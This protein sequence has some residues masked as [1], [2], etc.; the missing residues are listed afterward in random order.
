MEDIN[1]QFQKS[2]IEFLRKAVDELKNQETISNDSLNVIFRRLH[3]I[4]GTAQTFDNVNTSELAHDL[5]NVLDLLRSADASQKE[6]LALLVEGFKFLILSLEYPDF[7]IPE[8]FLKKIRK[9]AT[10]RTPKL[11]SDIFLTLI[12]PEVFDQLTEYE[13]GKLHGITN[14]DVNI[15]GVDSVFK[16]ENVSEKL[17]Q[18]QKIL[19]KFGEIAF[20]LPSE[21]ELKENEIGFHIFIS[22]K[23]DVEVISE[24][25]ADFDAEAKVLT[26]PAEYTNNLS[27]VLSKIV[28]QGKIWA[29]GLGKTVKF[30]VLADEPELDADH[31]GLIFEILMHLVRNAVDHSFDKK[32]NVE[33]LLKENEDGIELSISDDGKGIDLFV[34]RAKAVERKLILPET[35]L[36]ERETLDL[37]FMPGFSTAEKVTELSGRG[38]GLDT[39]QNLVIGSK[40]TIQVETRLD[41]GTTFEIF[42]PLN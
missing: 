8:S 11:A 42:L 18:L 30:K 5:E 28:S 6:L 16:V 19:E 34:I 29:N 17:E 2:S 23:T 31:L 38:V 10:L 15:I 36:S 9:N 21:K 37:I 22:S 33:I 3:T 13:K 14:Q 24:A 1:R 4:K 12:P 40:G 7:S 32:G 25:I 39:V 41:K 35:N 26:A 27:G 20:S